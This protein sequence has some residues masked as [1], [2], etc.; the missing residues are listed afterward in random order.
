MIGCSISNVIETNTGSPQG[1]VLSSTIFIILIADIEE[2]TNSSLNGYTDDTTSSV[3]DE[4]LEILKQKCEEEATKILKF[5]SI[6]KLAANPE[7]THI[8][9]VR[10]NG[11]TNVKEEDKL[12]FKIGNK[13]IKESGHETLL[14]ITISNDLT[15]TEQLKILNRD[16]NYRLFTLRRLS[17]HIPL[18]LLKQV[19]DG[20]FMSKLRYGL[21]VFCPIRL[22]EQEPRSTLIDPIKVTFNKVI[23]LLTRKKLSDKVSIKSMLEKLGWLSLNQ[24]CTEVRLIEA[25]KALNTPDSPLSSIVQIKETNLSV[26]TRSTTNQRI[27]QSCPNKLAENSFGYP[28]ARAWN[29]APTYISQAKTLY[30]AK[31]LI[32]NFV[33]ILP[34]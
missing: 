8:L 18:R 2:W 30:Q 25:W 1:A 19:A 16:L 6:N 14:G 10:K 5:M 33:K 20:I 15:W 22:D 13:E 11:Q 17:N 24:L 26:C 12:I 23:R 29:N 21:A 9:V 28:T 3:Y 7:K 27:E 31:Q 32:R 4:D 34:L